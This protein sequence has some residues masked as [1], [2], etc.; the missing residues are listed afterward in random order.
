IITRFISPDIESTLK[1]SLNY[2]H[3]T[4]AGRIHCTAGEQVRL[5]VTITQETTGAQATGH[6]QHFCTGEVQTWTAKAVARGATVFELGAAEACAIA[7][8]RLH[9]K[10]TDAFSWCRTVTLVPK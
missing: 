6:S 1:I 10:V 3:V 5:D 7:V 9:G 2:R 8:T 4:A